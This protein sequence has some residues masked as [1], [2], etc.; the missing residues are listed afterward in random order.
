MI[1]RNFDD[2]SCFSFRSLFPSPV[3][4]VKLITDEGIEQVVRGA[5]GDDSDGLTLPDGPGIIRP[6]EVLHTT[7]H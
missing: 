7:Q 4:L 2:S 5:V 3:I 1:V 6:T